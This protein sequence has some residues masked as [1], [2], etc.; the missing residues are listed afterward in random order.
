MK[1]KGHL[2]NLSFHEKEQYRV[3][4]YHLAPELIEG[5][6]KQCVVSDVY[7][8]GKLF[9]RIVLTSGCLAGLQSDAID[10]INHLIKSCT[11]VKKN[12]RPTARKIC[13][14]FEQLLK[15]LL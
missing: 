13:G 1:D 15:G 6:M 5:T 11:S 14:V 7:S 3:R 10:R 9:S 2:Y 12:E 4:H 8:L